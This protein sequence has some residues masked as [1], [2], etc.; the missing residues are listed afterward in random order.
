MD[1]GLNFEIDPLRVCYYKYK[2]SGNS[3]WDFV[4]L[5]WQEHILYHFCCF[6]FFVFLSQWYHW[7][8]GSLYIKLGPCL[9]GLW[10]MICLSLLISNDFNV[11]NESYCLSVSLLVTSLLTIVD[12]LLSYKYILLT[13]HLGC[14]EIYIPLIGI[15]TRKH[16]PSI[17]HVELWFLMT[18][19]VAHSNAWTN[20]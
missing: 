14:I 9:L 4:F 13:G 19:H 18:Y 1:Y 16:M 11:F 2:Y 15:C 17:L 10:R 12:C 6:F 5:L 7:T 20:C 8:Y 3:E